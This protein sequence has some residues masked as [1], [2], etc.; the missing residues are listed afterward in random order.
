MG[1]KARAQRRLEGNFDRLEPVRARP[2]KLV[3]G[4]EKMECFT[5][6][7]VVNDLDDLS[8][9]SDTTFATIYSVCLRLSLC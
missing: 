9:V 3:L 8:E 4:F 2:S 5:C 7:I 6:P 1:K